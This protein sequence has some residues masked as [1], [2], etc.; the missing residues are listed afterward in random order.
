MFSFL[1]SRLACYLFLV[2]VIPLYFSPFTFTST[3]LHQLYPLHFSVNFL[4]VLCLV[5]FYSTISTAHHSCPIFWA[6]RIL[7]FKALLSS[8]F[9]PT[10]SS[11]KMCSDCENRYDTGASY[12]TGYVAII[13]CICNY[14]TITTRIITFP[15]SWNNRI[16]QIIDD[17][18]I[19][20]V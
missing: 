4:Q 1:C 9:F 10:I 12:K 3:V 18:G 11:S 13:S 16:I 8:T 2:P 15:D 5:P 14:W 6:L 17:L 7:V 20:S 19:L